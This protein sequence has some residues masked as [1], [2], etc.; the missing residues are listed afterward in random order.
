MATGLKYRLTLTA[1]QQTES[2]EFEAWP[3][4]SCTLA[5]HYAAKCWYLLQERLTE[6]QEGSPSENR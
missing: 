2:F 1:D 6:P 5:Q 4:A 3:T